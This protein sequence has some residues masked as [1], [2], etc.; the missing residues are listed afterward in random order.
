MIGKSL[1]RR[2]YRLLAIILWIVICTYS[3]AD[4]YVYTDEEG[5]KHF[6]D[7][8]MDKRYKLY[9]K[10][11]YDS[12]Y[13]NLIKGTAKKHNLPPALLKAVIKVESDFDSEAVS[14]KGALG[15]M[16]LLPS[17]AKELG[18]KEPFSPYENIEGGAKYLKYLLSRFQGNIS[19]SLAAYLLGPEA[20]INRH[21]FPSAVED[22]IQQVLY[23]QAFYQSDF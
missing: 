6:T 13:D 15:L 3:W 17:T 9:W 12:A 5:V 4:I 1:V 11:R 18:V 20:V 23:Y 22:Y 7:A 16:Q 2:S 14:P 8:P 10:M 19:Q 21:N